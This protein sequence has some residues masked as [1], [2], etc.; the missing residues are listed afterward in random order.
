MGDLYFGFAI[1]AILAIAVFVLGRRLAMVTPRRTCDLLALATFLALFGYIVLVWDQVIL[2]RLLPFS[3]LIVLGNWFPVIAAF[4]AGL[5]WERI[6]GRIVRKTLFAGSLLCVGFYTAVH[7]LRG[8]VPMCGE[9]WRRGICLQTSDF[10]CSPASAVSVLRAYGIE[11]TEQEL[12][13]LCLTRRGTTW[14]GLYRG[15]KKKTAGTEWDVEVFECDLRDLDSKVNGPVILS[16]ELKDDRGANAVYVREC[17][18]IPGQPHSVVLMGFLESDR[19]VVV[20][21]DPATGR[22]IWTRKD[23]S[24]LWHGQGIRLVPRQQMA[25]VW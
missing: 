16:V 13:E 15:L 6:P 25:S 4:M 11:A 8:D 24:V 1:V 3:N 12:A 9:K 21:G 20:I 2:S 19:N 7:P 23:L 18:W 5:V 22:E 14:T 10:T 17:G